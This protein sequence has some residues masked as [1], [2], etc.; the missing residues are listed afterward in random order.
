MIDRKVLQ[1]K[2][3]I[4]FGSTRDKARDMRDALVANGVL[5]VC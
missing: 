5:C 3:Y 4:F 2:L 1:I